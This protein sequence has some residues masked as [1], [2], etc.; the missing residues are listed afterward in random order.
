MRGEE[1]H[2]LLQPSRVHI[3]Y[4]NGTFKRTIKLAGESIVR[5]IL[6]ALVKEGSRLD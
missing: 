1:M 2:V 6:H 3:G 5:A 4:L